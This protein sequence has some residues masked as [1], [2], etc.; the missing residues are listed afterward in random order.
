MKRK[1]SKMQFGFS[2]SAADGELGNM[3][4]DNADLPSALKAPGH[5]YNPNIESIEIAEKTESNEIT[6]AMHIT[7]KFG[8]GLS[9]SEKDLY[10]ED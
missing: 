8:V 5:V 3:S 6:A 7:N 9:F 2:F 1:N 10:L 4:E